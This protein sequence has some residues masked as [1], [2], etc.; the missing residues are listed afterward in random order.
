MPPH[1]KL[2]FST[3]SSLWGTLSYLSITLLLEKRHV[4]SPTTYFPL[5]CLC[6]QLCIG[7]IHP[8]SSYLGLK[9]P[10]SSFV[11]LLRPQQP[12]AMLMLR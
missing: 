6:K 11:L 12:A 7:S 4:K 2:I 8:L 3:S 5:F 1:L 9:G 10:G